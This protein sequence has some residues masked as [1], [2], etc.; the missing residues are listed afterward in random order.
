MGVRHSY[1]LGEAAFISGVSVNRI[2]E[3]IQR[4]WI[5]LAEP[6]TG[7]LDEE[8]LARMNLIEELREEFGVNDESMSIILHLLDQVYHLQARLEK[9]SA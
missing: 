8:D 9:R 5:V 3:F 2:H 7:E 6:E 1:K 4:E